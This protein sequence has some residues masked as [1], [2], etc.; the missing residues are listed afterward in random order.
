MLKLGKAGAFQP[1]CLHRAS[2]MASRHFP[3]VPLLL[4]VFRGISTL[5]IVCYSPSV[6]G[7]AQ[8]ASVSLSPCHVLHLLGA[9]LWLPFLRVSGDAL[10]SFG[11]LFSQC[12]PRS[13][14]S[15]SR[16]RADMLMLPLQGTSLS[17][18]AKKSPLSL[19]P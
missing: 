12:H 8:A 4:A 3:A 1:F 10:S 16:S 17:L 15:L 18:K 19:A 9:A 11:A 5:W 2:S 7:L 6:K 14:C 13:S